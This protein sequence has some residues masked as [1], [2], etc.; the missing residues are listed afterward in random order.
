MEIYYP[1]LTI[2]AL[3]ILFLVQN[4]I[5]VTPAQLEQKHREIINEADAKITNGLNTKASKDDIASVRCE[6]SE[7]KVKIDS[8]YKFLLETKKGV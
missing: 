5:F 1:I 2:I 8:I 4:K 7:I 3:V 6:L